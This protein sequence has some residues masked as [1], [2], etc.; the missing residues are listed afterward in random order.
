MRFWISGPTSARK[1]LRVGADL[2]VNLGNW[3]DL[4]VEQLQRGHLA[5]GAELP[6]PLH[7]RVEV[8]AVKLVDRDERAFSVGGCEPARGDDSVH[9]A[10]LRQMGVV[11]SE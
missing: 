1:S 11:R 6:Q 4:H 3:R 10:D 2:L 7:H 8:V 5:A 9:R